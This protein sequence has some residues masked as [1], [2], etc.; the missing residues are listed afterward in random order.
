MTRF[1]R[2]ALG[3][4]LLDWA[5]YE[6]VE[7]DASANLQA[8]TVVLMS[9]VAAG[10]G[11]GG[12]GGSS[13]LLPAYV[14]IA[15]LAWAAWAW[16]TYQIGA[17]LLPGANTRTNVGEL[18]RTMGFA[19]APGILRVFG[20]IPVL[21]TPVFAIT[22]IW[23]LLAMIVAVRQSLDYTSTARAVAV[24]VTGWVLTIVMVILLSAFAAPALTEGRRT[25]SCRLTVVRDSGAVN[26]VGD[27]CPTRFTASRPEPVRALS[28]V[29]RGRR[30]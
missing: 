8:L 25:A 22:A 28:T 20:V 13:R 29:C 24:C 30:S 7:A 17:K 10:I 1:L 15:L 26:A 19:A 5:T 4:S 23:M 11:A 21:S 9:A 27:A 12:F 6:E 14:L 18:L 3:A 16:L 2:R